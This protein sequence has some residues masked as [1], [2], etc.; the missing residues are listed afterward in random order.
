MNGYP[1][2]PPNLTHFRLSG[3]RFS[4]RLRKQVSGS[5][6]E[7]VVVE[8]CVRIYRN[9]IVPSLFADDTLLG[10]GLYPIIPC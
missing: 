6:E 7:I 8:E 3:S 9:A 2:P 4:G 5:R 10:P 1:D